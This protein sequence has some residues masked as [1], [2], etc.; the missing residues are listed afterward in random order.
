MI[1]SNGLDDIKYL[2]IIDVDV[3]LSRIMNMKVLKM[4][5]IR[6]RPASGPFLEKQPFL[7]SDCC[8]FGLKDK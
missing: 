3:C 2:K 1:V 7:R 6:L 4:T 8:V 5:V